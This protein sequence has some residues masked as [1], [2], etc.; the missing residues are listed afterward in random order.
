MPVF[1]MS[2]RDVI[3]FIGEILVSSFNGVGLSQTLTDEGND[4]E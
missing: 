3:A 2:P 4:N 1:D